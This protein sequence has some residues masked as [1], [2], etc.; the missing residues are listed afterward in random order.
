[1]VRAKFRVMEIKQMWNGGL[2]VVRLLP[3]MAKTSTWPEGS[4]E[5]RSFWEATPSGE[6]ELVYSGFD[7]IPF[8]IGKCVYIDMME[9]TNKPDT[10]RSWELQTVSHSHNLSIELHL[11]WRDEKF[12]NGYVKMDIANQGAWPPFQGKALTHW[13]V[14][15]T[16]A[17]G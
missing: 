12:R 13:L 1:M 4:E 11:P 3:V 2:T 8:Q 10:D 16:P 7:E 15:I 14:T 5:N 17:E 9:L 6:S